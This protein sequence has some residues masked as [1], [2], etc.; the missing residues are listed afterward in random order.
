[1]DGYT[2]LMT[3]I[4]NILGVEKIVPNINDTVLLFKCNSMDRKSLLEVSQDV[5]EAIKKR[6]L[7]N[8][9][10]YQAIVLCLCRHYIL[11]A[12]ST[13]NP[14]LKTLNSNDYQKITELFLTNR[15]LA[16][17]LI[18]SFL[19]NITL[20]DNKTIRN[21]DNYA[22]L[23]KYSENLEMSFLND[24]LRYALEKIN[25]NFDDPRMT[26]NFFVKHIYGNESV[27]DEKLFTEV[28]FLKDY[29]PI[30]IRLIYADV[31]ELLLVNNFDNPKSN[32][33]KEHIEKMTSNKDYYLYPEYNNEQAAIFVYYYYINDKTRLNNHDSLN[34]ENK[35]KVKEIYPL[36]MLDIES[37][38]RGR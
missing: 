17:N 5:Y 1:M 22:L 28:R 19:K 12:E 14:I 30:V 4:F 23:F 21:I 33:I 38:K 24:Y 10:E 6:A 15:F 3:M 8:I 34:E 18:S 9:Q 2:L 32:I 13:Y 36:Y 11:D 37:I 35:Q 26:Y 27:N 31:Y 16:I 29:Y 25:R 7:N 20:E